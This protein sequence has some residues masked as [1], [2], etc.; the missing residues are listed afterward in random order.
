MAYVKDVVVSIAEIVGTGLALNAIRLA[1]SLLASYAKKIKW[2]WAEK[3]V[4]AVVFEVEAEAAKSVDQWAGADK[5][6]AAEQ[7]LQARG[8]W[9]AT[10]LI[11]KVVSSWNYDLGALAE[12]MAAPAATVLVA[13]TAGEKKVGV[14]DPSPA[15]VVPGP[16]GN[17][18]LP[19]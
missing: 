7:K 9:W 5:R 19:G 16:P 18:P 10:P 3:V 6:A 8:L 12:K 4:E 1:G 14:S 15:V 2:E 13:P 17:Y 11:E